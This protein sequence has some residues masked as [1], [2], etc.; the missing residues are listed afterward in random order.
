LWKPPNFV[1]ALLWQYGNKHIREAISYPV[2]SVA[3]AKSPNE[4][5][6]PW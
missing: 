6:R 5:S 4:T 3:L 2:P 1:A